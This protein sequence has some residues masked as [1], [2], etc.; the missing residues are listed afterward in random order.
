MEVPV[1]DV[2]DIELEEGDYVE[3]VSK[4]G[5]VRRITNIYDDGRVALSGS[6]SEVTGI[7]T[8]PTYRRTDYRILYN[9]ENTKFRKVVGEELTF[10]LLKQ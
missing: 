1:F 4:P 5:Y 9:P 7:W 10:L 8:S 2:N 3:I 6:N